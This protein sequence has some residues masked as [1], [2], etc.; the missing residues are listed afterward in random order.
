MFEDNEQVINAANT[1]IV[2]FANPVLAGP[3]SATDEALSQTLTFDVLSISNP[4]LFA[5]LPTI[6]ATGNLS[7]VTAKDLNGSS[8]VVVQLRRFGSLFTGTESEFVDVAYVHDQ[9]PSGQRCAGV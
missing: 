6:S 8:V 1:T 9:R 4:G 7:F 5:T 2:G 3:S